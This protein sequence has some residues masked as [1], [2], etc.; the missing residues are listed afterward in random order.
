[1]QPDVIIYTDGA[2][3]G[4][5]GPGGWGF[6]AQQGAKVNQ[7]FGGLAETTNNQMELNAAIQALIFAEIECEGARVVIFT[8]SNYVKTGMESWVSK[9][10]HNGWK[11]AAGKPVKNKELWI[12][13]DQQ[14][15]LVKPEWRWVK[16]HSGDPGNEKAD[17]LANKG[18]ALYV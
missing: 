17:E 5:P 1:M 15:Q 18:A 14:V 4:N 3:K 16:G 7:Y 2:C 12:E 8:D 9:W 11:T 10:K 13:L 6:Y